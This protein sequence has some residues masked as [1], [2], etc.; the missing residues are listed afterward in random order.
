MKKLLVLTLVLG[1]ASL[2]SAG[3][4]YT[5]SAPAGVTEGDAFTVDIYVGS[6][7]G[8]DVL[9]N[10]H[11]AV[12]GGS[13]TGATLAS[14]VWTEGTTPVVTASA[15]GVLLENTVIT[16]TIATGTL[17]LSIDITAGGPGTLIVDA[18]IPEY[19]G[20]FCR[21]VGFTPIESIYCDLLGQKLKA[22]RLAR[23]IMKQAW[24]MFYDL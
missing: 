9:T 10:A 11:V 15:G 8:I 2:A 1:M 20:T 17:L 6:A 4:Y 16:N 14:G 3:W 24:G 22:L 18:V 19:N 7:V 12:T 21:N 13:V 5:T 23:K